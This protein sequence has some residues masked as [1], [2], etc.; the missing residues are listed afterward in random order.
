MELA[1]RAQCMKLA[2]DWQRLERIQN[3]SKSMLLSKETEIKRQTEELLAERG[4]TNDLVSFY[5]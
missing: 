3:E 2:E 1:Y 4:D 5:I